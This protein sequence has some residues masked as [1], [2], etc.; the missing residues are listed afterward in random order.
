[1]L[2]PPPANV[3]KGKWVI[4]SAN[5]E[6][7]RNIRDFHIFTKRWKILAHRYAGLLYFGEDYFPRVHSL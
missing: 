7:F 5:I 1:M 2:I 3:I 4:P 6:K